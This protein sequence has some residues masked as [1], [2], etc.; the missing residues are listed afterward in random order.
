MTEQ[1][2]I[3]Q[4]AAAAVSR[5][6]DRLLNPYRFPASERAQDLLTHITRQVDDQMWLLK[7]RQ[8]QRRPADEATFQVTVRAVVCDLLHQCVEG[9]PRGV[10]LSRSH[11]WPPKRY[12]WVT[13]NKMLRGILDALAR[14]GL[15]YVDQRKGQQAFDGKGFLT[16][17]QPSTRFKD[18]VAATG[19]TSEDIRLVPGGEVIHLRAARSEEFEKAPLI[20]YQ[21]TSQTRRFRAEMLRINAWLAAADLSADEDQLPASD[22]FP[23]L[24]DRWLVRRFTQGGF[25]TGG[26]LWGGFWG[27]MK[28]GSRRSALMI[29]EE[30]AVELDFGQ[31]GARI[32]YGLA[33]QPVPHVDLYAVPGFERRREGVKKAMSAMSFASRRLKKMPKDVKR[34]FGKSDT[35]GVVAKAVEAFH[36]PIA[37]MFFVGAGHRAQRIE[38]DIMVATLLRLMDQGITA[39]PVHDAVMVSRSAV[40]PAGQV[41]L[42]VFRDLAGVE[43]KLSSH[44]VDALH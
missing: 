29:D 2:Q 22:R 23:D 28:K 36:W 25:D 16:S 44:P 18:M 9:N 13:H 37:H 27:E 21:D 14:G 43:G 15:G 32:L 34:A 31:A 3:D 40:R 30:P 41:M 35:M 8:R 42:E 12:R 7:P 4:A 19:L 17:L 26:R 33:A 1:Q 11:N 24:S 38:S 10:S 6:H 5:P 20:D 39:L